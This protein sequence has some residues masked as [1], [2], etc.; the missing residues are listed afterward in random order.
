MPYLERDGDVCILYLGGRSDVN[1]QNQFNPGWVDEI[2]ALLDDV[3]TSTGPAGLVTTAT[4][5]FYS[6]GA[7]LSWGMDNLDQVNTFIDRIQG[8]F[9]RMLQLPLP[10][11]AALQGHTFGAGAFWAMAHDYRIMRADR[12]FLCFPG[13]HIGAAY[14]EG[15]V[16]LLAARLHPDALHQ[17]LTTGHR[18]GGGQALTAGLVH[19]TASADALLSQAVDRAHQ[20]AET[21]GPTL[22]AIKNTMYARVLGTLSSPMSG[23]E[24]QQWSTQPAMT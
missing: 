21:R 20:L 9:A 12:G 16:D 8:L 13:V 1:S 22:G 17:A 7:D 11:V 5:K 2:S 23:A 15:T 24:F 4:G 3:E 19:A 10:T 18:Y 14:S 6:T